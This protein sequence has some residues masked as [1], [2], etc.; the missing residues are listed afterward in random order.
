[1]NK[2]ALK[3]RFIV[4]VVLLPVILFNLILN[5]LSMKIGMMPVLGLI[6]SMVVA[7]VSGYFLSVW[8][9]LITQ[10]LTAVF[11][12]EFIY[13]SLVNILTV[14][15]L[16]HYYKK[17]LFKKR[18]GIV[19]YL[20]LNAVINSVVTCIIESGAGHTS[21]DLFELN[22]FYSLI[23]SLPISLLGKAFIIVFIS[24]IVFLT[25]SLFLAMGIAKL[26]PQSLKDRF[27]NYAWLQKPVSSEVLDKINSSE[28]RKI[29][30]SKVFALSLVLTSLAVL[31]VVASEASSLFVKKTK[32]EHQAL[33]VG[34]SKM[35]AKVLNGDAIDD[36]IKSEGKSREYK[37]IVA[38]LEN[39]RDISDDIEYIYVYKMMPDG[40]H[41]IYDLPTENVEAS[42]I[43][44]IIEYS[45]EFDPYIAD[46]LEGKEIEPV[47]SYSYYGWLLSAYTPVYNSK[48]Q[49]VCY[50]CV[51]V[52][53]KY[54][55]VY[56]RNF[57]VRLL[58]M[59]SGII[60]V[61]I[62]TGLWTARYRVIYPVDSMVVT[63]RSFKY[64][65]E[66]ARIAN[67]ERMSELDICTGDE[68]ERLYNSFIQVTKDSVKS[69][70]KMRQKSDYIEQM[71]SNLIMILA[72][73]VENRDE[74]TGDHIK[75][76]SKY[77]YIIMNHMRRMGIYS[78]ILTEE[79]I[80]NVFKSAPPHDIGKIKIPDSILNKP[81][82]LTPEEFDI[83]KKHSEYGGEVI[84][85][86][87]K[88][89]T[90]ASYLETARDIAL[91]H[92]EKW[93]GSGYP[94]GLKGEEIPLCARI[95]A[96]ADVFDA[97][98][99]ERVYKKAFSFEKA[100]EII[101]EESGTHFDPR[102]VKAFVAAEDEVR[103]TAEKFQ[104]K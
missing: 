27:D 102:I 104:D 53:M 72:D 90:E 52:S 85:E 87:I 25:I 14:I 97:L 84:D 13:Y 21:E 19:S 49:T 99:S 40:C 59:C 101:Q 77:T 44:D 96:V 6:G 95:M 63:A 18:L 94:K 20:I 71:Q 89:L 76:T 3:N 92:H 98:V 39:I 37:N 8:V 103:Q 28:T 4:F 66:E 17:G 11:V 88:S 1:M 30:I 33:A 81:G 61:I 67:V 65:S 48:G 82:K 50:A 56:T 31:V 68:I 78:G 93:D 69:F 46:L 54:L 38:K 32:D 41:V 60:I 80:D 35:V 42:K 16:V 7:L 2:V 91:Y 55:E 100:M 74:S 62:I 26:I 58:I 47:E 29:R 51:D 10:M 75:K 15:F 73:M 5:I 22:G 34:V 36:Y 57:I 12:S 70:S 43:G 24:S 45:K 86:L 64:D 23:A 9:V 79:Y 83:M